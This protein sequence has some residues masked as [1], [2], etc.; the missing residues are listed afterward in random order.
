MRRRLASAALFLLLIS[1][2]GTPQSGPN[3]RDVIA[4]L[5]QAIQWYHQVSGTQQL[6]NDSAD[7][8][9]IDNLHE[10]S[11]DVLRN[12]FDFAHAVAALKTPSAVD[13]PPPDANSENP[14][15]VS[16]QNLAQL[17]AK[18]QSQVK[19]SQ[20]ELDSL[21]KQ[22]PDATGKKLATLKAQIAET[23]SELELAQARS[24][25]LNG[26]V[27]FLSS[28]SAGNHAGLAAQIDDLERTVPEVRISP[29][30]Q[31]SKKQAPAAE[32]ATA[33]SPIAIH[34]QE[35][36]GILG[37]IEE[38]FGYNSKLGTQKDAIASTAALRESMQKLRAPLAQELKATS[39]QGESL[40]EAPDLTDPNAVEQRAK[41]IS[42]LT[43]R[44][45]QDSAAVVPLGKALILVDSVRGTLTEWR[46]DTEVAYRQ[47]LKRLGV[48]LL[49]LLIAIAAIFIA[50]EVWR[51]ATMRYVQDVRRRNQFMLLRRIV[52]TFAMFLIVVFM[53]VTEV[54]SI[55]TFAGFITAGL[56]VAL[57]T[58][59]LSV[60]AYFLLIGKWGIR[61]GDRVSISGV[62][63]D[64]IDIG[65]VRMHLMEVDGNGGEEQPTGRV[66]VFSNAVMFQP[67]ANFFKQIP[68][69]SFTWHRVTLTLSPETDYRRAEKLLMDAV[70]KVYA[71]YQ[72]DIK[73]QHNF[74]QQ[75]LTV[76][77]K[78]PQP[79]SRFR[80]I[81]GGLELV[82][83]FPV[84]LENVSLIDDQITR[85]LVQA[86]HD[87]PSLRLEKQGTP[88]IQPVPETPHM[89]KPA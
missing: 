21:E 40:T 39:Q 3:D 7:V 47:A 71:E 26:F 42:T 66:A 69:T 81:E 88:A 77:V 64:V 27:Q 74:M 87:E 18:A 20:E 24:E 85:A 57:Q 11:L 49:F 52:V 31:T 58:V 78:V 48:R 53:L 1:T 61:V 19:Q 89:D 67:A 65:L 56:A 32:P 36:S 33:Q 35:S 15:T 55:A 28:A 54:G 25:T 13:T 37:M 86:I 72:D 16:P 62:T 45:K 4:F 82:I 8:L 80:F 10:L 17:A 29:V 41:Q 51:K 60:V 9:Y 44:F 6:A 5:N 12:C 79:Q 83:R 50:S 84:P 75:T 22:L 46:N 43:A 30:V 68:G 34:K 2:P 23:R 59:I 73:R 63:G 70:N 14:P 38:S 76:H